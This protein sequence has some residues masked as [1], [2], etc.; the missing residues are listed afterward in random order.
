MMS[1]PP[2][3]PAS[4]PAARLR[5][6]KKQ[7]NAIS[8]NPPK[9]PRPQNPRTASPH[10]RPVLVPFPGRPR[11]RS[12]GRDDE[13]TIKSATPKAAPATKAADQA[14][15]P[16]RA[17][18]RPVQVLGRLLQGQRRGESPAGGLPDGRGADPGARTFDHAEAAIK[19]YLKY[20][21][22]QAE[23]WMYEWLVKAIEAREGDRAGAQDDARASRPSWPSGPE[24][25]RPGPGGRHAGGPQV[26]RAGRRSPASRPNIGE[27]VDLAA[28]KVPANADPADDVDQPGDPRQGPEAD[29]RRRRAAALAG[30][31]RHRRQDPPRRQGA[32]QG[33]GQGPPRRRPDRRGRRPAGPARRI[34]GP[35]PLR[36]ADL[37]RR[38]RHRPV[39][40]RAA[41]GDRRVP[42]PPD[43]LRRGDRQERLRQAPRGGLRLPPGVRRRLHDHASRRSYND[44]AKP[45]TEATLEVIPT[46]GPP[47]RSGRPTRS[48]ST[49]P[50]PGRRPARPAAGG[51]TSCRS[52]PRPSVRP[53]AGREAPARTP[54]PTPRRKA[55][56]SPAAGPSCR[57]AEPI[58]ADPATR[59]TSWKAGGFA[60]Y[61]SG[62]A[63]S[64]PI[65][66]QEGVLPCRP[67][68]PGSDG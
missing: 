66:D 24:P 7:L 52:S 5:G 59:P 27:L 11:R 37:D 65:R 40:R 38:G 49:K 67:A 22:K 45:V 43:R 1:V 48:T 4:C 68:S 61:S 54:A 34:R 64:S 16:G 50:D 26:L 57:S 42:E 32:G 60:L 56:P 12:P 28:E 25:E 15:A 58:G 46:R 20:H 6:K 21:G 14:D 39:R 35:R 31:A 44:P 36:P 3:D 13:P 19:G 2:Q 10:R 30:L 17:G 8:Q 62:R 33:P 41:R 47:R 29:G 23:P 53:V 63:A 18:G 55:A 9:P 51:R